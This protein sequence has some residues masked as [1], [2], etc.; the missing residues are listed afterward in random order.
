M[1]KIAMAILAVSMA[2]ILAACGGTPGANGSGNADGGAANQNYSVADLG[3]AFSA[4]IEETVLVDEQG[5]KITAKELTYTDYEANLKLLLENNS[6]RD[7]SFYAGTLGYSMNSINGYMVPDGYIGEDVAVGMQVNVDMSFSLDQLSIYG[8]KDIADIGLGFQ[9]SDENGDYLVTGPLAIKTSIADSYDYSKD[10]FKDAMDGIV[11]PAV[12]GAKIDYSAEDALYDDQG[13]KILN[14]YVVTNKNG[15]QS[16][17]MEIQNSSDK[18]LYATA[19]QAEVNGILCSSAAGHEMIV[20]GKRCVMSISLENMLG[21][22]YMEKL[23][24]KAYK[25]FKCYFGVEDEGGN[26]LGGNDIEI[27]FGGN[28][29]PEDFTSEMVYDSN[30]FKVMNVGVVKDSAEYS[31]DLHL[32][33]LVKNETDQ[34]VDISDGLNDVYINKTK[35]SDITVGQRTRPGS[36]A[37]ID[38]MLM[39]YDLEANG[40]DL[41]TITE[42]TV[43]LEMRDTSYNL[44]NEAEVTLT[45]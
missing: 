39:D 6:D 27:A 7:L 25:N 1:K 19:T 38:F 24:M 3:R 42:A 33:L 20:A 18:N 5:V 2:T 44:L 28:V 37:L 10:T 34:V 45:Y 16:V 12:L 11:M 26:A 29:K 21:K 17:F 40:I 8:F 43:K 35:I 32:L 9:I 22:N 30:G 36:Y 13:I 15:E 41:S 4:T 23:G 14:E 31:E